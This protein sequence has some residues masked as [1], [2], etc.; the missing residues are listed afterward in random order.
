MITATAMMA[1][2]M[3]PTVGAGQLRAHEADDD[4]GGQNQQNALPIHLHLPSVGE[5]ESPAAPVT[6][7][8]TAS[9]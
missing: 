4:R 7:S 8:F 5:L 6:Q 2:S 9:P 3:M 1:T